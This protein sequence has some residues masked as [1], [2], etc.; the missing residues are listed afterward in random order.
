MPLLNMFLRT[1]TMDTVIYVQPSQDLLEYFVKILDEF[2]LRRR[3]WNDYEAFVATHDWCIPEELMGSIAGQKQKLED[4]KSALQ[5]KYARVLVNVR[6][7]HSQLETLRVLLSQFARGP[8]SPG[9]IA[10][11]D[12]AQ[13]AKLHFID[14]MVESGATYIG[15]NDLNLDSEISRNKNGEVYVLFFSSLARGDQLSWASNQALLLDLLQKAQPN[16]FIAIFDCD[17]VGTKLERAHIRHF[18]N[19]KEVAADLV[20]E[21]QFLADKCFAR[22]GQVGLETEDI[23]KPVRRRF[24]KIACPGHNCDQSEICEWL[25]PHC[26]APIEFGYSDQFFYCDCGRNSFKNYDFK[27]KGSNHG[28]GY[29]KYDSTLLNSLLQSLDQSNY[30]N[31]LILGETG[32]VSRCRVPFISL[33]ALR[34]ISRR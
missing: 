12:E 22:Y 24:V 30:Q 13:Q 5:S 4:A 8:S 20:E 23:L 15:Y 33:C 29:E 10:K 31:I 1:E 9:E 18:E 7:G 32:C 6:K 25:C 19:G 2:D 21:R 34:N 26:M 27:C 3:K 14:K 11:F 16:C 17:A 28:L